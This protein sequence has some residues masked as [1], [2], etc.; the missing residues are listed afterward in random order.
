MGVKY[1]KKGDVVRPFQIEGNKVV[2]SVKIDNIWVANP[3]I[4]AIISNGWEEFNV[5]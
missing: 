1:F 4:S 5:E 2:A 3:T